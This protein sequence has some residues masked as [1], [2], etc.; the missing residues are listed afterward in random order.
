[1]FAWNNP[2]LWDIVAVEY[3][4]KPPA[5]NAVHGEQQQVICQQEMEQGQQQPAV[6]ESRQHAK[7]PEFWRHAPGMW[8]ARAECMSL[9]SNWQKFCSIVDS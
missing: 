7:L 3:V 2:F 1:M 9:V 5:G 4:E 8:F 6:G